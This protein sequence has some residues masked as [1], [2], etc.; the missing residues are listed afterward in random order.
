MNCTN[1][2]LWRPLAAG[3]KFVIRA[4]G[5]ESLFNIAVGVNVNGRHEATWRHQE[6]VPGPRT[7]T[8]AGD[9]RV[10]FHVFIS[11]FHEP[12][13]SKPVK[14]NAHIELPDGSTHPTFDCSSSFTQAGQ[15]PITFF[16]SNK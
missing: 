15:F 5:D 3:S 4:S 16:A 2:Q 14:V 6:I 9:E 13:A 10:T 12:P 8:I 7:R 11:V 1:P